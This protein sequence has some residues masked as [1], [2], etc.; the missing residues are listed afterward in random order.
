MSAPGKWVPRVTV[1]GSVEYDGEGKSL[2]FPY[3]EWAAGDAAQG[4]QHRVDVLV[5]EEDG[6]KPVWLVEVKDFRF[7]NHPPGKGNT[8]NIAGK[9]EKKLT[10]T[11]DFLDSSSAA[12][13]DGA[14][15]RKNGAP[16]YF[17]Y[18]CEMPKGTPSPYFPGDIRST[19]CKTWSQ[20]LFVSE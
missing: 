8:V 18:H 9:L 6:T 2:F 16:R 14:L 15:F 10:D 5:K 19:R 13:P 4:Q 20:D 12:L 1:D 17:G 11:L 7:I 3:D